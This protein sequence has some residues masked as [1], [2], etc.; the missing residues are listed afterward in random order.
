MTQHCD[1]IVPFCLKALLW[2]C[3]SSI[4]VPRRIKKVPDGLND[5]ISFDVVG[6]VLESHRFRGGGHFFT[7][8]WLRPGAFA[9]Y[10]RSMGFAFHF[11]LT[12]TVDFKFFFIRLHL[13]FPWFPQLNS[14]KIT[15]FNLRINPENFSCWCTFFDLNYIRL[16]RLQNTSNNHINRSSSPS[17]FVIFTS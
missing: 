4:N 15:P 7:P 9:L 6:D 14:S 10:N 5:A 17:K 16:C 1:K 12:L 2:G 8:T 3:E 13:C 11:H